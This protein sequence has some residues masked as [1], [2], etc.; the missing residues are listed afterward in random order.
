VQE[1]V[2]YMRTKEVTFSSGG[3]GSPGHLAYEYFAVRAGAKGIHVAYRGGAPAAQAIAGH[4]VDAGIVSP[5][6]L[7]PFITQG[8]VKPLAVLDDK[9]I[10]SLSSVPTAAEGGIPD[11]IVRYYSILLAPAGTPAGLIEKFNRSVRDTFALPATLSVLEAA[12]LEPTLSSPEEAT[13]ILKEQTKRWGDVIR[14]SGMH[15]Q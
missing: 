2:S 6:A 15:L 8:T 4:E 10:K 1:F 12:G 13:K 7:M 3:N 5:S 14:A 11:L 9:R